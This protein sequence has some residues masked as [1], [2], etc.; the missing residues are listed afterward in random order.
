MQYVGNFFAEH[1]MKKS[2]SKDELRERIEAAIA[3][4]LIDPAEVVALLNDI[5]GWGNQHVYLFKARASILNE[6]RTES[7]VK[8][9]L[10]ENRAISLLNKLKP[11]V[12][13]EENSL[14]S[15]SWSR[16]QM[17][18]VWITRRQWEDRVPD[19]DETEENIMWKAYETKIGRGLLAF[20]LNLVNGNAMLMIQRLPV[21]NKYA[22]VKQGMLTDLNNFFDTTEMDPVRVGKC[23]NKLEGSSEARNRSIALETGGG[24][25]VKYTSKSRKADAL[26]DEDVR[27]S[28]AALGNATRGSH[29]NFY[30]YPDGQNIFSEVHT[31]I[32][33]KDQRIGIFGQHEESEIRHV[34]ARIQHHSR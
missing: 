6:W 15:I 2:G 16:E 27:N 23:I 5:E 29:G 20:D 11:L 14:A 21:G 30:W 1:G 13:P 4:R 12:L 22:E 7:R 10:R 8:A 28:R 25:Q 19:E 31:V 32:Y 3:E 24:N 26:D 18:F 9:I 34:I 33:A 17:R